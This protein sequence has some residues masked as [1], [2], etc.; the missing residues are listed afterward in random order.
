MPQERVFAA[1]FYRTLG[2]SIC[3]VCMCCNLVPPSVA[4][5]AERTMA[6]V[7]R[8]ALLLLL[9]LPLLSPLRHR[10]AVAATYATG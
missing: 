4:S 1:A 8:A 3:L 7:A 2:A 5:A 10:A 6:L 9:R